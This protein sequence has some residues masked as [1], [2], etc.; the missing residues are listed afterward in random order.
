[1][2]ILPAEELLEYTITPVQFRSRI[3]IWLLSRIQAVQTPCIFDGWP[4]I[5]DNEDEL[6]LIEY[7]LHF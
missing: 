3:Y 4:S 1:M 7:P 5:Q 6:I 2:G